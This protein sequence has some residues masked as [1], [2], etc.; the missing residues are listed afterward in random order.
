MYVS[1]RAPTAG[2][3]GAPFAWKVNALAPPPVS[4]RG[5][6]RRPAAPDLDLTRG[7][8]ARRGTTPRR[9]KASRACSVS[10]LHRSFSSIIPLAPNGRRPM[11]PVFERCQCGTDKLGARTTAEASAAPHLAAANRRS[12]SQAV[13]FSSAA[14]T[15]PQLPVNGAKDAAAVGSAN[16]QRCK[17]GRGE[18]ASVFR[19][20]YGEKCPARR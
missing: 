19:P 2:A 14:R 1:P 8:F 18:A 7:R 11:T 16:R 12:K 17:K 10:A 9:P 6:Q 3:K 4:C 5:R 13:G 20:V 15:T